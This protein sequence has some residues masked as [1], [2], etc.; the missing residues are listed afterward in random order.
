MD[1]IQL[2]QWK[3]RQGFAFWIL[4]GQNHEYYKKKIDSKGESIET[5]MVAPFWKYFSTK[6]ASIYDP[7]TDKMYNPLHLDEKYWREEFDENLSKFD[8]SR[9]SIFLELY[10]VTMKYAP[11]Q[12]II[13][14]S[15][16]ESLNP[17]ITYDPSILNDNDNE[18]ENESKREMNDNHS[19]IIQDD[20]G[21]WISADYICDSSHGDIE[22]I[23]AEIDEEENEDAEDK[24]Q[25]EGEQNNMESYVT[26]EIP[27]S[28]ECDGDVDLSK[29]KM[30]RVSTYDMI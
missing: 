14:E 30:V 28:P 18:E 26:S 16:P 10:I 17:I 13:Y 6:L 1:F 11:I 20:D 29:S 5:D 15:N 23:H 4:D 12:Q 8:T 7:V 21:F 3:D 22:Y 24:D 27:E 2:L 25:D 19:P 9:K